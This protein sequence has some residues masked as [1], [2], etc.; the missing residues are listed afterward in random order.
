MLSLPRRS[1]LLAAALTGLLV[2]LPLSPAAAFGVQSP[3]GTVNPPLSNGFGFHVPGPTQQAPA[4]TQATTLPEIRRD[5]NSL[6][7]AVAAMREKIIAAAKS[8]DYEQMRRVIGLSE[9]PPV[10]SSTGEGDPIDAMRSGAGDPDGLEI[11]A[12]LLDVLDAGWVV[13]D[14]GKPQARYIW[15]WF[16]E[17]PPEDLT[18][19]QLVEAYR[20][21]TAGDFEQM[22]ADGSYEFY[23]V[24]IAPD[25]RWL[26]FMSGE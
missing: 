24:E 15:P 23:R 10:L 13:K 6:P 17:Y 22:R 12:I 2:V 8:G 16:A 25:G 5:L 9:P 4:E 3:S 18:P 21:L 1:S 14:E 19:P 11:L 20:I 26:L 7:P